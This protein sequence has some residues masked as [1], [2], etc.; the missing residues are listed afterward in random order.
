MSKWIALQLLILEY[1]VVYLVPNFV[2]SIHLESEFG[3]LRI[4]GTCFKYRVIFSPWDCTLYICM[5]FLDLKWNLLASQLCIWKYRSH[6]IWFNCFTTV[7]LWVWWSSLT[8]QCPF[9]PAT[10]GICITRCT[11]SSLSSYF[12]WQFFSCL[13]QLSIWHM[14]PRV[15]WGKPILRNCINQIDIYLLIIHS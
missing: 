12:M 14:L 4:L 15:L 1:P 2:T 7:T 6:S 9:V 10:S 11:F 8:R 3:V 5:G 13:T